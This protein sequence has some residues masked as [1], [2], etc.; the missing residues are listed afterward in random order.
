MSPLEQ[1]ADLCGMVYLPPLAFFSAGHA[2]DDN[3]LNE[4]VAEWK[5]VL[6]ALRDRRLDI[7]TARGLPLL[8]GRLD[9]LVKG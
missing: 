8:N 7:E 9:T 6:A 1:T 2:R 3:R 5:G 4:F